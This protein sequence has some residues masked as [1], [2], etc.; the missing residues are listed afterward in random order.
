M[1]QAPYGARR[2]RLAMVC[3]CML[4]A[5]VVGCGDD[6]GVGKTY[7]VKG[8]VTLNGKPVTAENSTVLFKPDPDKGNRSPFEP[9]G[10]L[11]DEGNYT[12]VTKGKSGAPPGWYKVIVTA[13][14]GRA[15]HP[16]TKQAMRPVAR[17]LVPAK[18]GS[19]KTTPLSIE[20][21]ESPAPGAYDLKLT[22]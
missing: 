14:E 7:P 16:K 13:F 18:Y 10:T 1:L 11:D 4:A 6:S 15:E 2:G 8:Q 20:V 3:A 17:S 12:L 5:T 21:V 22:P 19:A 9:A